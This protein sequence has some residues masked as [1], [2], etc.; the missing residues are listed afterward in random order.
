MSE[1]N[2]FDNIDR[3]EKLEVDSTSSEEVNEFVKDFKNKQKKESEGSI[4]RQTPPTNDTPE[5]RDADF[6]KLDDPNFQIEEL[7]KQVE[8]EKQNYLRALADLDNYKKR[9]MKEKS[10]LLKYQGEKVILDLLEV[11]DSLELALMQEQPTAEELKTGLN[12]IYKLFIDILEKW[13][14]KS[15]SAI[16]E[17]FDPNIQ[18]ALSSIVVDGKKAGDI[19]QEFKKAYHYKDK[20]LRVGQV[21]VAKEDLKND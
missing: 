5:D 14:V 11:V 17:Q 7:K 20:L 16:G 10:E 9:A 15:K 8:A 13:G 3:D 4:N 2:D 21:V 6:S 18:D 19:V 1:N 12:L